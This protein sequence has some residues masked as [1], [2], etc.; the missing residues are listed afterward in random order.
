MN[1]EIKAQVINGDTIYVDVKTLVAVRFPSLPS[2]YYTNPPDA[3]YNLVTLPAG[4]TIIAKKK[5]TAPADLFVIE[6]KRTHKFIIVYSK[7]G[8]NGGYKQTD[9]DFSSTKKIKERVN[10]LEDRDKKYNEA[11]A[12]ADKL[13]NEQDFEN[14]KVFYTTALGL[15]NRPW[16]KDQLV[17]INKKLKKG[18]HRKS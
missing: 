4:F 15:L 9:Y 5:N 11:I 14:A 13:F 8:I 2:N 18:R 17:K 16:P 10:Q 12:S 3:P 1:F 6:N 7:L